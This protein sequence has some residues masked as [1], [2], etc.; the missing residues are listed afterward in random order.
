MPQLNSTYRHRGA[1]ALSLLIA[2]ATIAVVASVLLPASQTA[3]E[4][5][6]EAQCQRIL[7][8]VGL[9]LATYESDMG[10]FPRRPSK[11]STTGGAFWEVQTEK[12]GLSFRPNDEKLIGGGYE[13]FY[14]ADSKSFELVAVPAAPGLTASL[15]LSID[16]QSLLSGSDGV[17]V[18]V[19]ESPTPGADENR[20]LALS[21][22]RDCGKAAVAQLLLEDGTEEDARCVTSFVKDETAAVFKSLDSDGDGSVTLAELFGQEKSP[23]PEKLLACIL[24]EL[25]LGAGGERI[26]SLPGVVLSDLTREPA[27]LFS[28]E[29]VRDSTTLG[30]Q[31]RGIA[32]AACKKLDA[33]EEA[34][35][36]GN[37]RTRDNILS[38]YQSLVSAQRGKAIT[39]RWADEL[40]VLAEILKSKE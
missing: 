15:T 21:A 2:V 26:E 7:K 19:Q 20:E 30:V 36:R 39:N 6:N 24:S 23:L 35:W 29:E 8:Q 34:E 17:R 38:A 28:Y 16:D 14:A 4:S 12:L 13:F 11:A 10:R 18:L 40:L 33:A 32:N 25:Q 1:V 27:D 31:K 22:I 9:A 5:A 3:R 37:Y